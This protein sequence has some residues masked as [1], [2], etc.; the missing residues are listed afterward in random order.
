MC[1]NKEQFASVLC[2]NCKRS[3][4]HKILSSFERNFDAE[5]CDISATD[6]Y[7][8]VQ[9]QGCDAFSFRVVSW[10]SEAYDP[11]TGQLLQSETLYPKRTKNEELTKTAYVRQYN[12]LPDNIDNLY[13]ETIGCF[14]KNFRVL[15][16][17]GVRALVEGICLDKNVKG[18]DLK[19]KI[20]GLAASDILTKDNAAI[21]HTHR[22]LGNE[23]VHELAIPSSEELLFSI[24][25]IE[26][27]LDD[28]YEFPAKKEA[29]TKIRSKAG[30]KTYKS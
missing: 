22:H 14:E 3:T 11:E 21:L 24:K 16:A 30:K 5:C 1:K 18:R 8:I 23:A 25:I 15:G 17:A 27:I 19:A 28:I 4:N 13:R 6:I 20:D 2:E 10:C 9:C 26:H 29:L 12:N 7:Q